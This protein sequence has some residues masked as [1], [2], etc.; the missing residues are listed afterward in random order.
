MA[1]PRPSALTDRS[2][3]DREERLGI[4]EDGDAPSR[5]GDPL[6]GENLSD[7][8]NARRFATMYLGRARYAPEFGWLTYDGRRWIRDE[9]RIRQL[10]EETIRAIYVEAQLA[11]DP[12]K[13]RRIAHHAL[14]SESA[15]RL[16]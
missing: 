2:Y 8:G 14:K 1:L 16:E 11:A 13:R 5:S 6:R 4:R 9:A 12:R 15:T 3:Y 10:A 7:L